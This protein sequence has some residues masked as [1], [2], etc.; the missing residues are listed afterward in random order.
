MNIKINKP[1]IPNIKNHFKKNAPQYEYI[2]IIPHRSNR[3]YNSSNIAKAIANTYKAI[4]QRIHSKDRVITFDSSMKFSYI[5]DIKQEDINFYF[6]TPKIYKNLILEKIN[7][8]WNK[9]TLNEIDILDELPSESELYSLSY[10]KHDSLS[11]NVDKKSNEPLNTIL[12]VSDIMK[13]DD[14][15]RIIYNF[16]PISQIGWKDRYSEM[17]EKVKN[18]DALEKKITSFEFITKTVLK[19]VFVTLDSAMDIIQDF[20]GTNDNKDKESLYKNV[21]GILGQQNSLS[22]STKRKKEATVVNVQIL[23]ES[24]SKDKTRNENN[25]LS[26]CQAYNVLAEDNELIYKKIKKDKNINVEDFDFKIDTSI[27]SCD[28]CQNLIQIPADTLLKDFNINHI[29][30]TETIIP[31]ELS[32]G[33]MCIG[34]NIYKGNKQECYLSTDKNFRNLPLCTIAPNRAGKT[35]LLKNLARDSIRNG[36]C[37]ILFDF[38]GECEFSTDVSGAID[39]DKIL[40][41]DLSDS[42]ILQGLGFNELYVNSN[43]PFEVYKSAKM[44]TSQLVDY[45]NS[46]NLNSELEPRM[47]RYLKASA[48]VVFINNGSIKDVFDV[49]EDFEKRDIFINKVPR[50]QLDNL[51]EYMLALRELDDKSKATKDCPSEVIGTKISHIQGILNRLDIIKSNTYME[52]MLKKSCENNVNLIDEVQKNQLICLRMPE[53]MFSTDEEKD[54]YCTYWINKIWGALQQRHLILKESER[55]KVNIFVDELY[56]VPCCQTFLKKKINQ[57]AKKTAKI[58]IS[59]HSL[60]QIKYIRPEL[61]NASTSYMLIAGCGKDNYNELKEELDPY[62]LQDLLGLKR[63]HSLNLIKTNDG[64]AKFITK[65]PPKI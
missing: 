42:K 64:Y 49:L 57:I 3:N 18:G 37:S 61:K 8:I 1:H 4:N 17:E 10:K 28:E 56:Q 34:T 63:Y 47:N 16:M 43:N 14:E 31:D 53:S 21:L 6:V 50:N 20:A 40:N 22:P 51:Q 7:E 25:A 45:I 32:D 54:I 33:I 11:L 13:D 55:T 35:N 60:E 29:E 27:F 65:L 2:Q 9:S 23:V 46:I 12:N 26:V 58:I 59:C 44:Q 30:N 52:L 24:Y 38:C 15:I 5:I 36:E 19:T 41:I 62:E 48:L 39:K